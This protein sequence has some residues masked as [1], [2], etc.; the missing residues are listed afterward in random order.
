MADVF[1]FLAALD[2]NAKRTSLDLQAVANAAASAGGIAGG[3][4][5]GSQMGGGSQAGAGSLNTSGGISGT[6]IKFTG[7]ATVLTPEQL[8]TELKSLAG[9]TNPLAGMMGGR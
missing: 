3:S 4:A 5:S 9:R 1:T 2:T 6:P 7:G 8:A